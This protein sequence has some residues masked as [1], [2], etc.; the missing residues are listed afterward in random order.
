MG[1]PLYGDEVGKMCFNP[2]KS[3]FLGWYDEGHITIDPLVTDYWNGELMGVGEWA[4]NPASLPAVVKIELG[5]SLSYDYYVGFNRAAGANIENDQG[6]DLVS[7]TK[8]LNT[9]TYSYQSHRQALLGGTDM[10]WTE[11]NFQ[12]T[13]RTLTVSV[14]SIDIASTPGRANVTISLAEPSPTAAPTPCSGSEYVLVL[15]T[16]KYLHQMPLFL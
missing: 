6:D 7:V 9:D 16:G 2:A 11:E 10:E 8:A 15:K 1:N 12:G 5:Q 4:A 13:G 14:N 3:M